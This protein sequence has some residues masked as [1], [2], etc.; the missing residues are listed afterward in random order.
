[1]GGLVGRSGKKSRG[2]KVRTKK[3]AARGE[4]ARGDRRGKKK[5]PLV[6]SRGEPTDDG[7]YFS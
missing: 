4:F 1:M 6:K 5:K 7:N 2:A 3:T